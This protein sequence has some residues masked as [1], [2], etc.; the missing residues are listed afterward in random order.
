[1]QP[2]HDVVGLGSAILDILSRCDDAFIEKQGLKKGIMRLIDDAEATRLYTEMGPAA[3]VGG[4]TVPN[5][6]VGV[7]SFG[8]K[9]AYMGKTAKDQFGEVFGHDLRAAGVTFNTKP[10]EDGPATGRCLI[11]VTPDGER[12]MSTFLGVNSELSPA[13]LDPELI[14][15]AK[16]LY[17]EGYAF[18]GPKA[19]QAFYEAAAAAREAKTTVSLTL[20]DP[21]CVERHR[22]AFLG[23]I[24]NDVD[25]L[26]ANHR[27]VLSLYQTEDLD[28]ACDQLRKECPLAVVTRSEKGSLVLTPEKVYEIEPEPV[29]HVVDT[30]GAGDLY[31]AGFLFGYARS[32]DLTTCG[33]L[34]SLAAAEIISHIGARPETSLAQLAAS[35]N[36]L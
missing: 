7:T 24:R 29:A 34:A 2:L 19:K 27:E 9:A 35:K 8:G 11:L 25:L 10:T 28:A 26:F 36:L 22:E 31:A 3:E 13:E 32:L 15:S 17:L 30:T 23:F 18:D 6:C 14:R 4:G 5:T 12:T 1:M 21:F 20:S 16:I 33:R